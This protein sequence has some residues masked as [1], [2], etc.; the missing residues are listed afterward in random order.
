[1]PDKEKRAVSGISKHYVLRFGDNAVLDKEILPTLRRKIHGMVFPTS[2]EV[3]ELEHLLHENS[4][5]WRKR[6]LRVWKL[7]KRIVPKGGSTQ[8]KE[9]RVRKGR[10]FKGASLFK[11]YATMYRGFRIPGSDKKVKYTAQVVP[12]PTATGRAARFTVQAL[13]TAIPEQWLTTTT[14]TAPQAFAWAI[15][16]DFPPTP[17]TP[18]Q[19][20]TVAEIIT[21]V[22]TLQE[23]IREDRFHEMQRQNALIGRQPRRG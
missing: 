12:L 5:G 16:P 13:Q 18:A 23:R 22:D 15:P 2:T 8:L 19:T 20:P 1:M 17:P 6:L 9:Y 7:Y 14:Q 11:N 21:H 3:V 10:H 4:A